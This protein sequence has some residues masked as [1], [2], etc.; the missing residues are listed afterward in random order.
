M[1]YQFWLTT[2]TLLLQQASVIFAKQF[3][4][5]SIKSPNYKGHHDVSSLSDVVSKLSAHEPLIIFDFASPELLEEVV[6]SD[7]TYPFLSNF[8]TNDVAPIVSDDESIEFE[9]DPRIEVFELD[10]V[11]L[12]LSTILYD[13]TNTDKY[14]FLFKLKNAKYDAAVLDEFLEST[15]V[16]LRETLAEV[17]NIIVNVRGLDTLHQTHGQVKKDHDDDND[18]KDIL[19]N[20]WTEGLLMCL[21]VSALLLGILFVAIS[22]TWNIE[23]SY[24]GLE[25]PSNPIKKNN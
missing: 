21:L 9:N 13:F 18:D 12:S 11:P 24:G 25:R 6:S 20:T 4:Y 3:S 5:L 8:L 10:E 14:I 19:S 23:I 7:K 2:L 17:E 1:F 16:F 15:C 22:W